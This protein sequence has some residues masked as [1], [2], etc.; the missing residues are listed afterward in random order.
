M[1]AKLQQKDAGD[2]MKGQDISTEPRKTIA[3]TLQ[4]VYTEEG[5]LALY[6]GLGP[7]LTRVRLQLLTYCFYARVDAD[8]LTLLL[9]IYAGG[10][11]FRV[12]AHDQGKGP[13]LYHGAHDGRQLGVNGGK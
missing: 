12:N 1:Q 3:S 6:R 5:P 9:G 4:R 13:K 2:L 10:A 7:E 8:L 11:L